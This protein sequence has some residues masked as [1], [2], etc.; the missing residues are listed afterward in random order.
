M[1]QNGLDLNNPEAVD[2]AISRCTA[3]INKNLKIIAKA[4]G[5]R[6]ILS[7]HISRHSFAVRALRKGISI[8][9]VSK[10][11]AHSN[12]RETQIYARVVN[13]ELDKAMEVFNT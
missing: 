4:V 10:L 6:K 8:D 9:K 1:F 5:I 7:F 2:T 13:E 11:L 12:I 3:L